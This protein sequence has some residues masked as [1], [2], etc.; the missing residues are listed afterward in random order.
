MTPLEVLRKMIA[1]YFVWL[2]AA[3]VYLIIATILITWAVFNSGSKMAKL[4]KQ[5]KFLHNPASSAIRSHDTTNVH[6]SLAATLARRDTARR[7]LTLR[8]VGYILAPVICIMSA[9]AL[10]IVAESGSDITIPDSVN[11][12]VSALSGLMGTLNAL[13]FGL[14]PSVLAVFYALKTER[15]KAK[16]RAARRKSMKRAASRND[17]E[18]GHKGGEKS[19]DNANGLVVRIELETVDDRDSPFTLISSGVF[20][21]SEGS[22]DYNIEE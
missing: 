2:F 14:D 21:S 20:S 7:A 18:L 16:R 5:S 11:T 3:L 17:I 9:A 10:D 8:L 15:A 12:M 13:L 4:V 22:N 19:I 1:T 6:Q